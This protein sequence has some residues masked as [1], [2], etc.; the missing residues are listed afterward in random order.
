M[1]TLI[2]TAH[3]DAGFLSTEGPYSGIINPHE[4]CAWCWF[5]SVSVTTAVLWPDVGTAVLPLCKR[6][7]LPQT[8][9]GRSDRG[10]TIWRWRQTWCTRYV[11]RETDV[12]SVSTCPQTTGHI[13]SFYCFY[14]C[15]LSWFFTVT[16]RGGDDGN[17]ERGGDFDQISPLE[18]WEI[19]IAAIISL[20]ISWCYYTLGS[21]T[22]VL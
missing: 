14:V 3:S 19:L 6:V 13:Q 8:S 12:I 4:D 7:S 5:S 1:D 18:V 11:T 10:I 17:N 9:S 22:D 21:T 2:G 20:S 15:F 16:H